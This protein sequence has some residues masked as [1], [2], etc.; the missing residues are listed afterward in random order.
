LTGY[1]VTSTAEMV[2]AIK[3][4]DKISREATRHRAVTY[5]SQQKM[6]QGYLRVYERILA[7]AKKAT[8]RKTKRTT[9]K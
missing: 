2:K 4:I 8:T 7:K 3:N 1:I 9:K 6:T 5:F